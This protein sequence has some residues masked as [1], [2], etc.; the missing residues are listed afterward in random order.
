[1]PYYQFA[2]LSA[3]DLSALVAYLRSLPGVDHT[4]SPATAPYDVKPTTA[5][6]VSTPLSALPASGAGAGPTNGKYLAALTCLTCHTPD[7]SSATP[8]M[9]DAAKAFQGGKVVTTTI[10]TVSTMIETSNLTPDATGI[11]A[12]NASQVATAITTAKDRTG[13]SIC[14]MRALANMTASDA[15]DIGTYLLAIPAVSNTITMTCP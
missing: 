11:Q 6:W 2:N 8:K 7:A 12:Y 13:K 14:G 1:M 3:S 10:N 15:T 9:L 4:V 5:E